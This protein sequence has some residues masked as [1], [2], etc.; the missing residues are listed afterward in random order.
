[1]QLNNLSA[2]SNSYVKILMR[3]EFQSKV[4]YMLD[5]S[6]EKYFILTCYFLFLRRMEAISHIWFKSWIIQ[7][8]TFESKRRAIYKLQ[9]EARPC[10]ND[11]GDD[12]ARLL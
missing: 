5:A 2:I 12:V 1:M 6:G 7:L 11:G 9:L 3:Q 8:C 10:I 4:D